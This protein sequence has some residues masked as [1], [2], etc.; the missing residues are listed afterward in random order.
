MPMIEKE[1][2]NRTACAPDQYLK[3]VAATDGLAGLDFVQHLCQQNC[4]EK[5]LVQF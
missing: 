3:L 2:S 1:T 4:F 5:N